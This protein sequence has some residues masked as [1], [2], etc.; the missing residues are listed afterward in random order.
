MKGV[1]MKRI[2]LYIVI[3]IISVNCMGQK[4]S[5]TLNLQQ[6]EFKDKMLTKTLADIVKTK[7]DC[8]SKN[9]FYILDFF[10]S[11]LYGS[12]Y[13][14]S[15]DKFIAD[16]NTPKSIT[17]YVFINNIVFF[18]SNKVA[19]EI[20]DVL[21]AKKQY[22]FKIEKFPNAVIGGDYH[23]LIRRMA[24]GHYWVLLKTCVE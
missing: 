18:V 8:F 11:S 2:V 3:I 16:S 19:V 17:Y 21:P 15:I 6:I 23:F 20:F 10:Q 1:F 14:L 24:S 12:E 9:G 7:S 13:Y 5:L 4:K 22:V